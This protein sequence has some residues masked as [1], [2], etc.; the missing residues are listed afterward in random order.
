MCKYN[1]TDTNKIMALQFNIDF[2]NFSNEELQTWHRKM[3]ENNN[4][5]NGQNLKF[6][7]QDV[8]NVNFGFP[9]MPVQ[10]TIPSKN[11]NNN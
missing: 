7:E 1:I 4:K 3:A 10:E 11:S 2:S 6:V 5:A 9:N 8:S